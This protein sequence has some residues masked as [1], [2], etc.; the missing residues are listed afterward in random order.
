MTQ[1]AEIRAAAFA[2]LTELTERHGKVLS[3]RLLVKGFTFAGER[4]PFVN[5]PR[6]IFKP[7]KCRYPLSVKTRPPGNDSDYEYQDDW[8]D[9]HRGLHYDYMKKDPSLP[10]NQELAE[11]LRDEVPLIYFWGVS[12][13][14]YEAVFPMRVVH[15][16]DGGVT[17][18]ADPS[19][20]LEGTNRL[21]LGKEAL[22]ESATLDVRDRRFREWVLFAYRRQCALCRLKVSPLL[23]AAHI[24]PHADGGKAMVPNGLALC[25]IHHAAFDEMFLGIRPDRVIEIHTTILGKKDGLMLRYGL[26]ALHRKGILTPRRPR[27]QPDAEALEERWERFRAARPEA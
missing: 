19:G 16:D 7:E 3:T 9:E 24:R 15:A 13:G 6:G 23:D 12:K 4:I 18:Q 25:K 22:R 2:R 10:I 20:P 21:A 8:S 5:R 26:Q 1:D 27:D 14:R 17:L 11:A